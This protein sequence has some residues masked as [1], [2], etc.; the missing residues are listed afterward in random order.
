MER[1]TYL[2]RRLL[3]VIPTFLGITIVCFALTRFLPGGPV[4]SRL[5]RMRA[6]AVGQAPA[7]AM[8][9]S[10]EYRRQLEKAFGFDR[11]LPV[12]YW[13]WLVVNRM[14]LKIKSYDCPDKTAW[15]LIRSRLPVSLGFGLASF[16]ATYLVC[17]PLGIVKALRHGGAF[18]ALSSVLVFV[19]Y[20]VPSF[21]LAMMLKM[22]FCGT[23]EGLWSVFPLGGLASDFDAPVSWWTWFVDRAWHMALPV[24]CYVSGSFAMLTLLMKNSL[25]DQVSADYV[26]TVIAK[27]SSRR[28]AVWT[29]SF[30]NALIPIATGFGPMIGLLFAGSIIIETVFEIPGMGRLSWDALNG[31]DYAVF[32]ALLA[33]TALI[34]LIGCLVSDFLYMLID[35]RVDFSKRS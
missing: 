29:H 33:L 21:A 23:V 10:D 31:R 34:Q 25:M 2:V 3:L 20:A 11:P 12:Q 16:L 24:L 17:V 13:D 32:L 35:P 19:A 14:G 4:E 26:R 30:R 8:Q 7:E 27:G 6:S 9:V 28:R 1:L 22:C 18:D 15:E 5:M